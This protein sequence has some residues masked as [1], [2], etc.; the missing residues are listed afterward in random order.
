MAGYPE[1]H[2]NLYLLQR[3]PYPDCFSEGLA[4]LLTGMCALHGA[5]FRHIKTISKAIFEL[6]TWEECLSAIANCIVDK[7]RG[8]R[9]ASKVQLYFWSPA[10]A[11]YTYQYAISR[12]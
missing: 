10:E 8:H 7:T 3:L 1:H 5:Y 12:G 2:A 4:F 6:S 11:Q 9:K